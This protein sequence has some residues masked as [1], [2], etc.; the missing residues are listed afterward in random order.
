MNATSKAGLHIV[1]AYCLYAFHLRAQSPEPLFTAVTTT[2]PGV[3]DASVN[4]GDYDNDGDLD[5]LL[6]GATGVP[7]TRIY[8]N[9]GDFVFT[10]IAA[11]LPGVAG[12]TGV[13][14]DY[15][16]DGF[17]DFVLT[18]SGVSKLYRNLGNGSFAEV[19]AGF[20]PMSASAAAW[21]DFDADGDLDLVLMGATTTNPRAALPY[22]NRGD[23]TFAPVASWMSG[24]SASAVGWG[25]AN[26][27]GFLDL[28]LSGDTG[29]G[30]LIYILGNMG[31]TGFT[32][33]FVSSGVNRGS[34]DWA[35]ADGDGDLDML[36]TGGYRGGTAL[37][38]WT[39][40]NFSESQLLGAGGLGQAAFGDFD[41][42]GRPDILLAGAWL[43]STGVTRLYRNTG[44]GSFSNVTIALPQLSSSTASWADM[45]GDGRLDFLLTGIPS[46]PGSAALAAV[47]R[48]IM[49]TMNRSPAAPTDLSVD[50][51]P[52]GHFRFTWTPPVDP[53]S[54]SSTG[55]V[56]SLRIGTTP[57]GSEI[58]SAE[59]ESAT[60]Q[61]RVARNG[62][63]GPAPRWVLRDLPRQTY[64]WSVQAVDAAFAGSPFAT[65]ASF[66][67]TN[68]RPFI[69]AISNQLILPNQT[70]FQIPFTVSDAET[71]AGD[72]V[73][74]AVSSNSTLVR[75][76]N[77]VFGGSGSNR[78]LT[79]TPEPNKVGMA[80]ILLTVTDGGGMFSTQWF[81]VTVEQFTEISGGSLNRP[82]GGSLSWGDANQNV[83]LDLLVVGAG[84][85]RLYYFFTNALASNV[86]TTNIVTQ[87]WYSD[88]AWGDY[89]NDGDLDFAV[90]GWQGDDRFAT[91]LYR[92]NG[93]GSFE[94]D[95]TFPF[96]QVGRGS[97]AWGDYDR[98]GDL[99]LLLCGATGVSNASVTRV[100]RNNGAAAG[101]T[102]LNAVLPGIQSGAAVWGDFDGD[103][104]L[105]ILL[106]GTTNGLVSG[107]I[108]RLYRNAGLGEFTLMPVSL[109]GA[110]ASALAAADFDR[111]GDLDFALSG[112]GTDS[113]RFAV[114]L[115]NDGGSFAAINAGLPGVSDGYL[116]WGD[117]DND[118]WLDLA[119]TGTT[120]GFYHNAITRVVRNT[121]GTF[122]VTP[123][124]TSGFSGSAT[125]LADF[126]E[127]GDLDLAATG[128]VSS[129]GAATHLFR[130]NLLRRNQPPSAPT[131]PTTT[132]FGSGHLLSWNAAQDAESPTGAGL[133]YNLR[134]GTNSGG[135]QI[136]SPHASTTGW[137]Y[138]AEPGNA[139]VATQAV[140]QGLR[141][142]VYYWS[143]QAV[144]AAFAGSP[145]SAE[146]VFT[147]LSALPPS[148]DQILPRTVLEDSAAVL[149]PITG[150]RRGD[151]AGELTFVVSNRNPALIANLALTNLPFQS[152]P[153]I[154]CQPRANAFGSATNLLTVFGTVPAN[155]AFG[156]PEE[157]L[158][159]SRAF[160]VTVL[161]VNDPPVAQ[162]QTTN[163][164]EDTPQ[165]IR[166]N[167]FDQDGDAL[168][169]EIVS[170]PL[171]G[172]LT[173]TGT[174]LTYLPMTNFFGTDF[175]SFYVRDA[176]T[177]S[178][179]RR[180]YIQVASVPDVT[181][182][183]WR[184][185]LG[186]NS[187][188]RLAFAGEPYQAY[189]IEASTDLVTWSVW[190]TLTAAPDGTLALEEAG[191][192]AY[193]FFRARAAQ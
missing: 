40:T 22:A 117:L 31:G 52:N 136:A 109:P 51:L 174:E 44:N 116:S 57:G 39:G 78:F 94:L 42:D 133:S 25:D 119:L 70:S 85:A 88:T 152:I 175:F 177:N 180:V 169:S 159:F 93:D 140:M 66:E 134:V 141:R 103:G 65:E 146:Q 29:Y 112:Q 69:S 59:S 144:D 125:A 120:T 68:T 126:D 139:G 62:N 92:N 30:R 143:V 34:I 142:G 26:A 187:V 95:W 27:D 190:Q 33:W 122:A 47:Y 170:A 99:D 79:V 55:H 24:Y 10:E 19:E 9:D 5:L 64:Y 137:R 35:D 72:L 184:V 107:G 132:P 156:T 82:F 3:T 129:G 155:P 110:M 36:A 17:L 185:T 111:D 162:V 4:W 20:A 167:V 8:R 191:A 14:G 77:I 150:V 179:V 7:I 138:V 43:N 151:V 12:G 91:H 166:L 168:A 115:R 18:G 71:D 172:T 21:G 81:N 73:V 182:T 183:R 192:G 50:S 46:T 1:L 173:G 60:G 80:D 145:F 153:S 53:D 128:G 76:T 131:N 127:D 181:E 23:G 171:Y 101:F 98:D 96:S 102:E 87:Q 83:R 38:R 178:Y 124:A 147:N 67:V 161:P 108:T 86:V 118:G 11:G 100:Y 165:V 2:L 189:D 106:S 89:D 49:P 75:S 37:F 28:G 158:S 13:W 130:N 32:G 104:W 114:L 186:T 15:D 41:H 45:D 84:S 113:N 135:S 48:N 148:F 54:G 176:E 121:G 58:M 149:I 188:V 105:D 160:V 154:S 56:Y 6:T 97:V 123:I 16:R 63:G 163:A 90:C 164:V 74:T 157:T 193:Q 61:R